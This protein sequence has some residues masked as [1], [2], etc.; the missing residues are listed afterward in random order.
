MNMHANPERLVPS[1]IEAESAL[2]GAL[3]VNNAAFDR[4]S[5]FLEAA[6]FHEPLH[7]RIYEVIEQM[8]RSGKGANPVTI[9]SFLPN[10][11]IGD[12]TMAAYLARLASEA[13]TV[14]NVKD[15]AYAIHE[16]WIRRRA[17]V[18]CEDVAA[19]AYDLPADKDILAEIAPLEDQLVELRAERIKG[20]AGKGAGQSYRDE[21]S[22]AY[23]RGEVLGVPI[24]LGE[25]AN[26]I[27]EPCFEAGNLYGLLKSSGEGGTSIICQLMTHAL[28]KGHPVCFLSFDQS[29]GQ[30]L[31][32]MVAQQH[33][34]EAR[35]QRD[36]RL[37]SEKEFETCLDFST[38]IDRQ[39]FEVVECTNQSAPQLFSLARTFMK[40]VGHRGGKTAFIVVDHIGAVTPEDRRADEGT[41]A[42][43]IGNILKEGA[44]RTGAAWL[45][46]SQ[47]NSFGMK[48]DNPRPISMD[49]FGGDPAKTPFDAIF[50]LYRFLK[51]Y[52]E[53][54]S[55][56][57]SDSDWKKIE[58]VF[59]SAVRT[60]GEDIAEIGAI[61]VRFGAANIRERLIFE[62]RFTRFKSDTPPPAQTELLAM[63]SI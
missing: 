47:R 51:F 54:K 55:I 10:E 27:S 39:P 52:E 30:I 59:P 35:R 43:G 62:A 60:D 50:Y 57:S 48:R 19:L 42:K 26:V 61:K 22:A 8:I 15:Y 46:I 40:R 20:E 29:R 53:R 13:V 28:K 36:A 31:R 37:L 18:A 14:I 63:E 32:Q 17:I 4:V 24:A 56:A 16:M 25:I 3:L 58:R 23:Q 44:R 6:H 21:L 33:E 5:N 49:L 2:L 9:K 34:I 38:W 11:N 45:V 12:M 41:K 7:R 1:N